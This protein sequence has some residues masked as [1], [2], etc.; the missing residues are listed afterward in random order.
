MTADEEREMH[1]LA[2][3][4]AQLTLR[5]GW[6]AMRYQEIGRVMEQLATYCA[7]CDCQRKKSA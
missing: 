5:P 3:K 4:L 7:V 2:M 6:E 1:V